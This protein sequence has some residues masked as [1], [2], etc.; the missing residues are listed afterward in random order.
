MAS[1]SCHAS[2]TSDELIVD[3]KSLSL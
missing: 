3:N 2:L 1:C